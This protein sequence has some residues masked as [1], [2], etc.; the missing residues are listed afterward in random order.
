M[1]IGMSVYCRTTTLEARH[2]LI[3]KQGSEAP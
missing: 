2:A 3:S 1:S